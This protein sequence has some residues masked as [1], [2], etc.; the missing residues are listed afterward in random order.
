MQ[1][2]IMIMVAGLSNSFAIVMYVITFT[3][4][5]HTPYGFPLPFFLSYLWIQATYLLQIFAFV[6]PKNKYKS[7]SGKVTHSDRR[8]SSVMLAQPELTQPEATA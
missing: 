4:F 6:P 1:S 3:N 7:D 2:S 8:P 5:Y